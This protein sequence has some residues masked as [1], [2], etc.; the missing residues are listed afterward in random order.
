M[1]MWELTSKK[2]PFY[3]YDHNMELAI[4][5]LNGLRP[6]IIEGTPDFYANI[7]KQ[8]W[9][10][11]PSKRPNASLLPKLFEEMLELCSDDIVSSKLAI[12]SLASI[13]QPNP[14]TVTDSEEPGI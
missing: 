12:V 7:M 6:E 9:D 5:I 3:D 2:P 14:D 4:S 11:D 13:S 10:S 1:I 8:C